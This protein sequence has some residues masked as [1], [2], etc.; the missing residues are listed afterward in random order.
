MVNS[1]FSS[2]QSEVDDKSKIA[3]AYSD[4]ML[5]FETM[6]IPF[7]PLPPPP[8]TINQYKVD[9]PQYQDNLK[10]EP[11]DYNSS[12]HYSI[13]SNNTGMNS[14]NSLDQSNQQINDYDYS[15]TNI[16]TNDLMYNL[17]EFDLNP[18]LES[19]PDLSHNGN[20]YVDG[21]QENFP[22]LYDIGAGLTNNNQILPNHNINPQPH[23]TSHLAQDLNATPSSYYKQ[24]QDYAQEYSGHYNNYEAKNMEFKV[25]P[26]QLESSQHL[27]E[28]Q[29]PIHKSSTPNKIHK[30]SSIMRL[31]NNSNSNIVNKKNLVISINQDSPFQ[32]QQLGISPLCNKY[33]NMDLQRDFTGQPS[34]NSVYH[35]LQHAHSPRHDAN[36]AITKEMFQPPMRN[37][38]HH[39]PS[40]VTRSMSNASNYSTSSSTASTT[41]TTTST[42]VNN[43]I[44][45]HNM[46]TGPA[47]VINSSIMPPLNVFRHNSDS[48]YDS[49]NL[50]KNPPT[51]TEVSLNKSKKLSSKNESITFHDND[52]SNSVNS[53]GTGNKPK[54]Y[55]RRRLLPR[56][57]LGCWICRIKHLKCDENRPVCSSCVKFGIDCDYSIDKPDYVLDKNLRKEKLLTISLIRKQNQSNKKD[58]KKIGQDSLVNGYY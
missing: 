13:F 27:D 33:R 56:S 8:I 24:Q 12:S 15:L 35:Q 14:N 44:I 6:N 30:K 36:Y 2:P 51:L 48:S 47:Q 21:S 3:E 57:K 5:Q 43:S 11:L 1:T 58:K 9:K 16:P 50:K 17:T 22:K 39:E 54:K 55:T 45:Y 41:S 52:S 25:E 38:S 34:P 32:S 18:S 4:Q 19:L 7:Q 49:I 40:I 26:S 53:N 23:Q 31:N 46:A 20:V 29:P 37:Q 28:L 10:Q 42:P